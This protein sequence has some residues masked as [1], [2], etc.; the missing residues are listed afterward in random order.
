VTEDLTWHKSSRCGSS[1]CVE[2]AQAGDRVLMRDSKNLAQAPLAFSG[3]EWADFIAG[4][5]EGDFD[6]LD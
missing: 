2:I 4:L 3:T 6:H 5:N 1:T